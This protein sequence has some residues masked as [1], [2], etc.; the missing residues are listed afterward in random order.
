M[1]IW[2]VH[3]VMLQ[4]NQMSRTG[5]VRWTLGTGARRARDGKLWLASSEQI[6][7][8]SHVPSVPAQAG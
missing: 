7:C 6:S 3:Y 4:S 5:I 2:I 8:P 1:G